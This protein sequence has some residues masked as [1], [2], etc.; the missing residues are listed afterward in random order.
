MRNIY[1]TGF[2]GTGKSAVGRELAKR[3]NLRLADIDDLIVGKEKRSIND[4]FSQNGEPYFRKVESETLKEVS[5]KENQTVSCGGGIVL[6]PE[7]TALMK[8]TGR[9]VCLSARPEV[10]FERVKRHTH[11]PQGHRP[12]LQV[13]DPLAKIRDLLA[14][15]KPY[16]EQAEFVIDTSEISVKEVVDKILELIK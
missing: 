15:R 3:L 1:L 2:M 10:I 13:A 5:L 16:Y 9:L 11:R 4:I 6:N 8:Q 14:S 7:N 12:L